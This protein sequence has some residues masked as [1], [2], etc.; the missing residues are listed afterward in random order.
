MLREYLTNKWGLGVLGFF[1]AIG[2][3]IMLSVACV[4]WYRYDTAHDKQQLAKEQEMLREREAETNTE[5]KQLT[6]QTPADSTPVTAEKPII[7]T[8][9]GKE[10]DRHTADLTGQTQTT[11]NTEEVPISPYGFGPYPEVP[12]NYFRQPSWLRYANSVSMPAHTTM[13]FEIMDRV[14]IK[15]WNQ[16][17]HNI[18]GATYSGG[19]VYPNYKNTAYVCYKEISLPDGTVFRRTRVVSGG[20][21]ISAYIKQIEAGNTP[22]HIKLIEYDSAGVDPYIFLRED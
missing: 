19:K 12:E 5:T 22:T 11:E 16:G 13:P 20:P 21:D 10:K 17:Q 2:F 15:L 6:D 3:L 14:L 4:L 1:S 7:K 9:D 8:N 18:T